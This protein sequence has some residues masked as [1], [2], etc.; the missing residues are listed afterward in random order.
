MLRLALI[1]CLGICCFL[2]L[3][4]CGGTPP[5]DAASVKGVVLDGDRPIAKA[6]VSFISKSGP[7][8]TGTTASDGTFELLLPSGQKGAMIGE[9]DVSLITGIS[10]L[11]QPADGQSEVSLRPS[12]QPSFKY[13]FPEP[14]SIQ[15]G[16]NQITL[17][18]TKATKLPN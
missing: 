8:A 4:G 13:L 7:K 9:N 15:K 16:M 10:E 2:T 12:P 18:V 11:V 14:V 17:D 3:S 6:E 5:L 1:K